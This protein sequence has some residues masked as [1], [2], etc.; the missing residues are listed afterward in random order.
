MTKSDYENLKNLATKVK[1]GKA[2]FAERNYFNM[3]KRKAAKEGRS[4]KFFE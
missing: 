3:Q 1:T 2:S 4:Y